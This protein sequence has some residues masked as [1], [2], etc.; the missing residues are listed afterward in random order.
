MAMSRANTLVTVEHAPTKPDIATVD[1]LLIHGIAGEKPDRFLNIEVA[2]IPVHLDHL[3]DEGLKRR[4]R[5]VLAI[6]RRHG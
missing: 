2:D 5:K 1:D 4:G 3:R 6:P